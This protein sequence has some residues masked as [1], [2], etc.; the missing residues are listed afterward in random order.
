MKG[1]VFRSIAILL[2]IWLLTVV[3]LQA[4]PV[5]VGQVVQNIDGSQRKGVLTASMQLSLE[6]QGDKNKSKTVNTPAAPKGTAGTLVQTSTQADEIIVSNCE[7]GDIA[8]V[9]V[10]KG[11]FPKWPLLALAAIPLFFL[12]GGGSTNAPTP[13]PNRPSL[14]ETTPS[15]LT[16]PTPTV[17]TTPTP[18]AP[19]S[20]DTTTPTTTTTTPTVVTTP[21]P[22]A[23]ILTPTPTLTPAPTPV[24][25][26]TT[27]LLF[28]S[29][30]LALSARRRRRHASKLDV[31]A[32]H[33]EAAITEG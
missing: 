26:P 16:T 9:D 2:S 3:P 30:L 22:T 33:Q 10:P 27:L 18:T 6:Q 5:L 12:G 19:T 20:L 32:A 21:T 28:G 1:H 29:G 4:S 23:P 31:G 14:S 8:A 13:P 15:A 7:C 17:P 25:E 24:P 11:G